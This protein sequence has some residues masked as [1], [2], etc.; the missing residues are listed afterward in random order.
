[1]R[2]EVAHFPSA[3]SQTSTEYDDQINL[4]CTNGGEQSVLQ[5][6]DVIHGRFI[7]GQ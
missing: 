3:D 2:T 5:A 7:Q 6:T 1:M 4:A